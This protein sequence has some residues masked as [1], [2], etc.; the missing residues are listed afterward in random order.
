MLG[1]ALKLGQIVSGWKN[2]LWDSKEAKELAIKRAVFCANCEHGQKMKVLEFMDD[3][4][5]EIEAMA[6][7]LCKC[8][9]SAKLRSPDEKCDLGKW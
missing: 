7:E 6:C 1:I 5:K 2:Y 9:L 8:P 4:V 3:D